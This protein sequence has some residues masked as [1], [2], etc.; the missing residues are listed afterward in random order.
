LAPGPAL[1]GDI[2]VTPVVVP[3]AGLP[4]VPALPAEIPVTPDVMPP[5]G[6]VPDGMLPDAAGVD[7]ARRR[8]QAPARHRTRSGGL[9]HRRCRRRCSGL[10]R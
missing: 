2:P 10:R 3:D 8:E 9:A 7:A 4:P 5:D 1:P 6:L